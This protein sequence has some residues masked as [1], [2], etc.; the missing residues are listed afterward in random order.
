MERGCFQ[1]DKVSP[2]F[3]IEGEMM[4]QGSVGFR[5]LELDN[6]SLQIISFLQNSQILK[7]KQLEAIFNDYF[8]YELSTRSIRRRLAKL[9]EY[10]LLVSKKL[11]YG[12]G[13]PDYNI[14]RL[15]DKGVELLYDYGL[16]PKGDNPQNI[17]KLFS[18]SNYDHFLATQEMLI[19]TLIGAKDLHNHAD[20]KDGADYRYLNSVRPSHEPFIDNRTNKLLIMPDWVV[21]DSENHILSIECDS[22]IEVQREI[23]DKVVRYVDLANQREG[24]SHSILFGIMDRSFPT[25]VSVHNNRQRRVAN[26][27]QLILDTV[28]SLPENLNFSVISMN[29]T[30]FVSP[31]ALMLNPLTKENR[32]M[33][34]NVFYRSLKRNSEYPYI[35]SDDNE[36]LT[37]SVSKKIYDVLGFEPDL[38]KREKEESS[39]KDLI[40][41]FFMLREG[42]VA[43]L[44][45]LSYFSNDEERD[46]LR[47][48]GIV[49]DRVF[50][51][52]YDHDELQND[53]LPLRCDKNMFFSS[54]KSISHPSVS[55]GVYHR[56]SPT[57]LQEVGYE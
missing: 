34:A 38:V 20:L 9:V 55:S 30:S 57:R 11:D 49:I 33:R 25:R 19:R 39:N 32:Q 47:S 2:L 10:G 40:T 44:Q 31:R 48:Q 50:G 27:K 56:F 14:Y 53:V 4:Y 7:T 22:G 28:G 24:E 13:A 54:I 45:K 46:K 41:L 17:N 29:R 5:R 23:S 21:K 42:D 8:G 26:I 12:V 16:W 6:R 36:G 35:P 3:S 43:G 1:I 37:K 18:K 52:Y 51:V 15:G